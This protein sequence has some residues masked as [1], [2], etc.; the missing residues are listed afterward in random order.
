[1][2]IVVVS[3]NLKEISACILCLLNL[4]R[5]LKWSCPVVITCPDSYYGY[6]EAPCPIM[7]GLQ[8][9]PEYFSLSRGMALLDF[10]SGATRNSV[11]LHFDDVVT[12]HTLNMPL[13][14]KLVK[15]L[16]PDVEIVL[17]IMKQ[18]ADYRQEINGCV[19]D[20]YFPPPELSMES[21]VGM[22]LRR[23]IDSISSKI[24]KH[25]C[26]LL[27]TAVH[28][29]KEAKATAARKR[30]MTRIQSSKILT[31]S[32]NATDALSRS[33]SLS[34]DFIPPP[35]NDVFAAH[36]VGS[37]GKIFIK[38]FLDTQMFADH[39][40]RTGSI[41]P[42][43][44]VNL[45][46]PR[47]SVDLRESYRS[48]GRFNLSTL[49]KNSYGSHRTSGR[50]EISDLRFPD[51]EDDP[52]TLIFSFIISGT[53]PIPEDKFESIQEYYAA[54]IYPPNFILDDLQEARPMSINL[55]DVFCRGSCNGRADTSLCHPLCSEIYSDRR[56]ATQHLKYLK[57]LVKKHLLDRFA[58]NFERK[59]FTVQASPTSGQKFSLNYETKPNE[60]RYSE[61]VLKLQR[62]RYENR[63]GE[64]RRARYNAA[65]TS[66]QKT[67]RGYRQRV[68]SA[69][70]LSLLKQRRR[71]RLL[72]MLR[73]TISKI[74]LQ[75]VADSK[76]AYDSLQLDTALVDRRNS[77]L[78]SRAGSID[79]RNAFST[80]FQNPQKARITRSSLP[81]L[82]EAPRIE[83]IRNAR[84]ADGADLGFSRSFKSK[85]ISSQ[86]SF[87]YDTLP[88]PLRSIHPAIAIDLIPQQKRFIE[89]LYGILRQGLQIY[90]HNM[91]GR[92]KIRY[93]Y[94]DL[95][96][97]KLYWRP[98]K[99][100]SLDNHS[101]KAKQVTYNELSWKLERERRR[102]CPGLLTFMNSNRVI[103][104]DEILEVNCNITSIILI[105]AVDLRLYS[106]GGYEALA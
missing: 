58:Q 102:R 22:D 71:I 36:D 27:N 7:L 3:K 61:L 26:T 89:D 68:Q 94:C 4:V 2:K 82:K 46:V 50:S 9:L 29:D 98:S 97:Q 47:D 20:T 65:A 49:Q 56:R 28:Q 45:L 55:G 62:K 64:S 73:D 69:E 41:I 105:M 74:E 95:Y 103:Y 24:H 67:Y 14:H 101:Q 77:P 60:R 106:Y 12:S 88:F 11:G 100:I 10:T 86:H 35:S 33:G 44:A 75:R 15:L 8:R 92:P 96:M 59:S 16:R 48:S 30:Q 38:R 90:K 37:K 80:I 79:I 32:E 6:L 52:W 25:I 19:W 51:P 39:S 93:L 81:S 78:S 91:R 18:F 83:S 63:L 84:S 21:E 99:K 53:S 104:V 72:L 70:L 17:G 31:A 66:V 42:P 43:D 85:S 1:M 57:N 76:C 40:Y 87:N 5:P 54:N 13:S 34:L 23:A